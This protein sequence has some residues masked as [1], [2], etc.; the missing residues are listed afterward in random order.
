MAKLNLLVYLFGLSSVVAVATDD[1]QMAFYFWVY[2]LVSYILWIW[3]L[4]DEQA[5]E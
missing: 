3:F 1:Y 5:K 2:S 4:M